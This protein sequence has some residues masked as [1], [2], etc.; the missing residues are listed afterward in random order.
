MRLST[1][2]AAARLDGTLASAERLVACVPAPYLEHRA[3]G[4]SLAVREIAHRV[5]R[6][7]L[8]YVDGMDMGRLPADWLERPAPGDLHDGAAVARY[9]ALVRGRVGGWFE[10]AGPSEFARVIETPEGPLSG[11]ALLAR[12]MAMADASL[13]ALRAAVD[14]LGITPPEPRPADARHRTPGT[15]T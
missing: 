9:G 2:D 6:V 4:T 8:A 3:A 1:A 5:F 14:E 13:T 12:T 11:G 7:A 10:G 15:A